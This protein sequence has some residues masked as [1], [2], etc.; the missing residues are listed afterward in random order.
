MDK[1]AFELAISTLVI[2]ILGILVLIAIILAVTG[3]FDRFKEATSPF[4]DTTT[5]TAV[6]QSCKSACEQSTKIVF[7]CSTYQ[8]DS[9]EVMCNDTRLDLGGCQVDCT[10]FNCGG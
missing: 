8:I 2:I 10:N 9:R 3:G 6:T 1:K 5:A 4:T 7:C